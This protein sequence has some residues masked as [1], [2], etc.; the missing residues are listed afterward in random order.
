MRIS[1]KRW[2]LLAPPLCLLA[3]LFFAQCA[4]LWGARL[5]YP[6]VDDWRYYAPGTHMPEGFSPS[7][8]MA[9]A[10][11]TLHATGKLSDWLILRL[12]GHDYHRLAVASF[13][14]AFGGWLVVSLAACFALARER[15]LPLFASLLVFALPLAGAPHWVTVS[16]DQWLEPAVAYHQMLPIVGLAALA[17]AFGRAGQPLRTGAEVALVSG[18]AL[19]F[20]L[21]YSSGGLALFVFAVTLWLLSL[22]GKRT[23]PWATPAPLPL[24]ALNLTAAGCLA[25]HVGLPI[26]D[27]DINPVVEARDRTQSLTSP[28]DP[29][30]WRFFLGVF[31]RALLPASATPNGAWRGAL[32][33]ALVLL[34]ALGLTAQVRRRDLPWHRHRSAIVLVALS[35]ALLAYVLVLSYGRASFG[36]RYFVPS[37]LSPEELAE[38]Y[39][40]TRFFF[41]WITALL[42]FSVLAWGQW[43]ERARGPRAGAAASLAIALLLLL[44]ATWPA[45]TAEAGDRAAALHSWR[46]RTLYARDATVLGRLIQADATRDQGGLRGLIAHEAWTHTPP[47]LRNPYLGIH[48][49]RQPPFRE[50]LYRRASALGARFVERW[51]LLPAPAGL[52]G[53]PAPSS[54]GLTRQSP[55]LILLVVDALRPDHLGVYGYERPT[56]PA[57]DRFAESSLVFDGVVATT[58]STLASVGSVLSGNFPTTH[59]L[60]ARAQGAGATTL[61][62]DVPLLPELLA[63]RGY[64]TVAVVA[65]PQ[66]RPEVGVGRGFERFEH[67]AAAGET[68]AEAVH[69]VARA[70]LSEDDDRPVFLY[71]HYVDILEAH[72]RGGA[73]LAEA[74][75]RYDQA[76]RAWDGSF[77]RFAAWLEDRGHFADSVVSVLSSHGVTWPAHESGARPSPLADARLRVPW[78]LR[79]AAGRDSGRR[80]VSGSLLDVPATLMSSLGGAAPEAVGGI[81]LY[82]WSPTRSRS[83]IAESDFVEVGSTAVGARRISVTIGGTQL[84][85]SPEGL[86]CFDL[87]GD[88][89]EPLPAPLSHCEDGRAVFA[90]WKDLPEA[91]PP[92]AE[93]DEPPPD[94]PRDRPDPGAG[95]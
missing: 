78:L 41:W 67:L 35:M 63:E 62:A 82:N 40:K 39:A 13:V 9:P 4:A 85:H 25:A 19:F 33:L 50:D 38:R 77:E 2:A 49:W 70:V 14:L 43:V 16:P 56:S 53:E 61:S 60:H 22:L 89:G 11:D 12:L 95:G 58:S 64:R 3:W 73:N 5:D 87:A 54:P 17:W 28:T 26:L 46:Y 24:L 8:I 57:L 34:P 7:W 52:P 45:A 31:D 20:G 65:H 91:S 48:E 55:H 18:T 72:A 83:L 6:I 47:S 93:G 88:T 90:R 66:L 74:V 68:D 76:I 51:R 80:A 23:E 44:P 84:I 94:A 92:K 15:T 32:A 75:E 1:G 30:F 29:R 59:R 21:S 37:A 42:P 10:A 86:R 79:V 69:H 27:L 36:A 81:D 71:L